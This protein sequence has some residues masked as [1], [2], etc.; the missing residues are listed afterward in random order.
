MREAS[1]SVKNLGPRKCWDLDSGREVVVGGHRESL[2][3]FF[4]GCTLWEQ[5][6]FD[7]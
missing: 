1:P 3:G 2:P 4:Y 5:G 7:C 6:V